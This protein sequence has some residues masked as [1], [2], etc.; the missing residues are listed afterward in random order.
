M[1]CP[2]CQCEYVGWKLKCPVCRTT[3]LK[4]KPPTFDEKGRTISY[5]AL[6][7]LVREHD[8][9]ININLFTTNVGME[10]KW[11]FP[12]RGRGYGWMQ[13][14]QGAYDD[15]QIILMTIDVGKERKWSFPY[16]GY[17]YA[18]AKDVEGT[19]G[20]IEFILTATKVSRE[21]R[22]RFPYFG[23]GRAW[24][25]EMSG[26]CGDQIKMDFST[27]QVDRHK[28]LNFPYLGYGFAWVSKG[29]L[30]I[31]LSE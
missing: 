21:K 13:S 9:P 27:T 10:K 19:I 20:G 12:Y 3:L 7:D 29:V 1:Y 31:S 6:V 16:F 5:E 24:T 18:W 28:E 15:L 14:M 2:E 17:G 26:E 23:Y 4:E 25:Q 30:T 8:G 11:S 22:W